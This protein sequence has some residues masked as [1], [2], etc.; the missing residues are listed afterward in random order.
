MRDESRLSAR[1]PVSPLSN[2]KEK[3]TWNRHVPI[4]DGC[5][6]SPGE[7]SSGEPAG[8]RHNRPGFVTTKR[9]RDMKPQLL[10]IDDDEAIRPHMQG[11]LRQDYDVHFAQDRKQ[12]LDAFEANPPTVNLLDLGLPPRPKIG[13][14]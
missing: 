9:T 11:A 12:A 6:S 8:K 14:A 2:D 10:I 1:R 5:G 13:R 3:G 7:N 4:K